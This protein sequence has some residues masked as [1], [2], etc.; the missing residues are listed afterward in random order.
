VIRFKKTVLENGI[1]VVSEMHS[2]SRAASLGIWVNTGTRD[3]KPEE[4]GISH[5]L[6]HMVFKGTKSRTSY[7]IS[8]SLEALGGDLNAFTTRE[9]TCYHALVLKDHWPKALDVLSDLVSNMEMKRADFQ[10]EKSVVLQEISMGDDAIEELIYDEYLTRCLPKHPLGRPILGTA[11]SVGAMTQKQV[12][13]K[14]R[15]RY[16]GKNL[17]VSAAGNVD[18]TELVD[19]VRKLLGNKPKRKLKF[20][21]TRPKHRKFRAVIEKPVEQLHLLLGMPCTSFKDRQRFEAFIINAMLGGGMTSK[22]YQSV[23]EKK[24]LV[25]SVYSSLNTFDDF[26]VINIY[27]SCEKDNMKAVVKTISAEL[28]RLK[29]HRVSQGDIDLF[30]TQVS[31]SLLLGSDDIENRMQ[32]IGVNEMVFKKY[33]P[34][35]EIIAEINAVTRRSV[36]EYLDKTFDLNEMG[37]ILMGGGA[38][39]LKDWFMDFKF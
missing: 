3:E 27:A 19:S 20:D 26:G 14:Y 16:S 11:E 1:S 34:V 5:F 37:A 38:E 13:Q 24:G 39:E 2:E 18:H 15:E 25:Y 28:R 4:A 30:K 29:K 7:Q 35:D 9:Y 22:L 33:K 36:N 21:R 10:L 23:R 17:I 6:E 31:G 32:S 12:M 8:K